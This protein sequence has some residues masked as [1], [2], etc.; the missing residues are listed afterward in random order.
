MIYEADIPELL[1]YLEETPGN[2]VKIEFSST[3]ERETFRVRLYQV[4]KRREEKLLGID[5]L[6]DEDIESLSFAIY[7]N[8]DGKPGAQ[9]SLKPKA[10][11]KTYKFTIVEPPEE[12]KA[13]G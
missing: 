13:N 8:E 4:K 9:I 3:S 1:E 10:V 7:L 12:E 2:S 5:Y 6:Q 11:K